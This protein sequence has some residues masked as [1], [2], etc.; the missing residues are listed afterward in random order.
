[1]GVESYVPQSGK[2][3]GLGS[4]RT[5]SLPRAL[6]VDDNVD[7]ARSLAILLKRWGYEVKI[8][9]DGVEAVDVARDYRPEVVLLDI[10][11]PRLSGYEVAEQIRAEPSLSAAVLIAITG[12]GIDHRRS[13]EAGF[14]Y[15]LVKPIRPEVLRELL[16]LRGQ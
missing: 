16:T 7:V 1:M 13:E 9:G 4:E 10:G 15:S 12:F 5:K 8:A 2:Q 11:L 3:F 14:D 6:V